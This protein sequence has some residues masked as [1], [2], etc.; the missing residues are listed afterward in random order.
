MLGDIQWGIENGHDRIA[1]KLVQSSPFLQHNTG[2]GRE[3]LIKQRHQFR[4]R[5]IFRDR[6]K[7]ANIGKQNRQLAL[8]AP[9]HQF[10]RV[11]FNL[12]DQVGR[13]VIGKS[14]F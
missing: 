11:L 2:H 3:I 10:I 12:L 1:N 7:A 5:K 13:N 9:Q 8:L 14:L 6:C 4:R